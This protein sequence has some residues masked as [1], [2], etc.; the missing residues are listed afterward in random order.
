M[1][2]NAYDQSGTLLA[3]TR[4]LLKDRELLDVYSAT[5]L[6]FYWLKKLA[7]GE[8]RNPSV[9]RVQFLFEYLSQTKLAV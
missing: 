6:S 3:K 5:G 9:N 2:T 1:K 8:I 4:C 7:S